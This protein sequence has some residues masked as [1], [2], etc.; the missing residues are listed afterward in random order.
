MRRLEEGDFFGEISVLSGAPR[1]RHHHRRLPLRA[2]RAG[3]GDAGRG[4]PRPTRTCARCCGSSTTSGRTTRSRRSAAPCAFPGADRAAPL[5]RIRERGRPTSGRKPGQGRRHPSPQPACSR[6]FTAAGRGGTWLEAPTAHD[7][8]GRRGDGHARD[9]RTR[10]RPCWISRG[11]ACWWRTTRATSSRRSGCCSSR[12]DAT[13]AWSRSPA[14]VLAALREPAPAYDLLLMDLNY[15]RD[16]T[17]GDEGLELVTRVKALDPHLPIVVM[18]A[19]ST[20][21]LAVATMREG[22]GDFV[23]K[24]WENARLL[25]IVRAQVAA[26][27]RR[28]R[29]QRLASDALA[30]QRRL[31]GHARSASCPDTKWAWPCVSRK[32]SAETPTISPRFPAAGW[33]WPSPTSA[34]RG[35]RPRSS[36]PASRRASK[37]SSPPTS[38]RGRCARAWRAP[39]LRGW[40]RTASSP[41]CTP[42]SIPR[43]ERSPTP[44][45][46]I[47]RP[48]SCVRTDRCGA[49]A[50]AD[51]CSASSRRRITRRGSSRCTGRPPGARHRRH[52]RSHRRGRRDELGD[53]GLLAGLRDLRGS[54]AEETAPRPAL[55]LVRRDGFADDELADDAHGRRRRR[56]RGPRPIIQRFRSPRA[57]ASPVR[58]RRAAPS[59]PSRSSALLAALVPRRGRSAGAR[60]RPG[61]AA[62]GRAGRGPRA[63]RSSSSRARSAPS[64]TAMR[65]ELRRLRDRFAARGVVFRLVYADPAEPA[66]AIRRHLRA[67]GYG[68][69]ALRDPGH[70]LVRLTG[71]TV[72]PE[73]AVFAPDASGPRIVYRGRIDDRAVDFGSHAAGAA[74]ARPRAGAGGARVGSGG[75]GADDAR[76]RVLHPRAEVI[77]RERARARRRPA[78]GRRRGR[79]RARH[80]LRR[81]RAA[82]IH[83]SPRPS[84]AERVT[85][86]RDVA[87]IVF[88]SC[89]PCH[90][91][92]E[93]G[94]FSLLTYADV[95]KRA[96]Q[97]ARVTSMRYMPPWPPEPG[98]RRPR[99]ERAT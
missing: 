78:L 89:V 15:A 77:A 49:C 80:V 55:A 47:P 30:V 62:R 64:P 69:D 51:R 83:P 43:R 67:F 20:V 74:G 58:L 4:S 99:R 48:C 94:P 8:D 16:T 5:V 95:Q 54:T 37:S 75:A 56:R 61:R 25:E 1:T 81:A 32:G 68:E 38:L 9:T 24:P 76:R 73:V 40:G 14:G 45:P 63:H 91:P 28:R 85:F 86:N 92:G 12:T 42:S 17:S 59:P 11:R 82:Q 53:E 41:S 87:P 6:A 27:R 44:T 88:H 65:P 26:G 97:I 50:G 36:W 90:R 66:D 46:A 18:T 52:H 21:S 31:L 72:T 84:A 29:T 57:H 13:C 3:Q 60:D 10:A 93:A 2:A 71:A 39:W 19:W 7:R 70:E 34:G 98:I 33:P 96:P 79:G 22:V 23:Q 35:R